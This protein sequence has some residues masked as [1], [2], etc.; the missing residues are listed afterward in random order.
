MLTVESLHRSLKAA[1]LVYFATDFFDYY[2]QAKL[3]FLVHPG[4]TV[5]DRAVPPEAFKSIY[6]GRLAEAGRRFH[7]VTAQKQ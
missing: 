2:L 4:F 6:A 5:V 1:G 3:L 7:T